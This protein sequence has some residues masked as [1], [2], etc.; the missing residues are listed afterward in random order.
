MPCRSRRSREIQV[1]V[2][3]RIARHDVVFRVIPEG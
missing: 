3:E 2:G 1:V